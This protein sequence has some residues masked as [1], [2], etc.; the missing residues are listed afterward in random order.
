[1]KG[2]RSINMV[3]KILGCVFLS[4]NT[5]DEADHGPRRHNG[6]LEEKVLSLGNGLG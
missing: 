6:A 3:E 1:M 4:Y 5:N 2:T